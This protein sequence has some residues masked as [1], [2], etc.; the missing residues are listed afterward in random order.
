LLKQ[1]IR[2][3]VI[4]YLLKPMDPRLDRLV[5]HAG[6]DG[7]TKSRVQPLQCPN[8][9]A[10]ITV[11]ALNRREEAGEFQLKLGES[12]WNIRLKPRS[13]APW[14]CRDNLPKVH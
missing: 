3:G 1:A 7:R 10:S 2:S 9:D 4:E 13:I 14:F 11:V 12:S 5:S 6:P 8:P